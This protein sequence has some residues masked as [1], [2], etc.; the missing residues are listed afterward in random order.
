MSSADEN[1]MK[2][3]KIA[4]LVLNISVRAPHAGP[5]GSRAGYHRV[6]RC[7]RTASRPTASSSSADAPPARL[8]AAPVRAPARHRLA[9]RAIA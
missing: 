9:S 4:K 1:A 8:A 7:G 2:K 6:A 3:L 5:L